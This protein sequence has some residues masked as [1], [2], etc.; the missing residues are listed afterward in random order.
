[1]DAAQSEAFWAFSEAEPSGAPPNSFAFAP[2]AGKRAV[3]ALRSGSGKAGEGVIWLS[4]LGNADSKTS[5]LYGLPI[6]LAVVEDLPPQTQATPS[7]AE[8]NHGGSRACMRVSLDLA[9]EPH[10]SLFLDPLFELQ[11]KVPAALS[12]EEAREKAKAF[13]RGGRVVSPFLP[14]TRGLQQVPALF[15][16]GALILAAPEDFVA[17]PR[18]EETNSTNAATEPDSEGSARKRPRS[19][20]GR[21]AVSAKAEAVKLQLSLEEELRNERL[22]RQV[23]GISHFAWEESGRKLLLSNPLVRLSLQL[24]FAAL[25]S[26]L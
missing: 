13:E 21:D 19:A 16:S 7:S 17:R 18:E 25:F 12:L 8:N 26:L 24:R 10:K 20:A 15:A 5:R 2:G 14:L 1:M 4:W 9:S 23:G 6:R 11:R 3:E 22:R